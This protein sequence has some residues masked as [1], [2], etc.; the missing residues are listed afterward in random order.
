MGCSFTLF[1]SIRTVQRQSFKMVETGLP[2]TKE[3][4]SHMEMTAET[5]H[6]CGSRTTVKAERRIPR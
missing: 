5:V 3:L 6:T 4:K 1:N 2:E